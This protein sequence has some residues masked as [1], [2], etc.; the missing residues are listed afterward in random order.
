MTGQHS[1][2]FE[3]QRHTMTARKKLIDVALPLEAINVASA[4]TV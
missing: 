4:Q 3:V 2:E 1:F